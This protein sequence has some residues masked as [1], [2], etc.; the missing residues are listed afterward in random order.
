MVTPPSLEN[1]EEGG[2]PSPV[3]SPSP[4]T[5]RSWWVN[6]PTPLDNSEVCFTLCPGTPGGVELQLP[7][8][9]TFSVTHHALSHFQTL[10]P[11]LP[12]K[13]SL[14]VFA[15]QLCFPQPTFQLVNSASADLLVCTTEKV[16]RRESALA[17]PGTAQGSSLPA[18]S[19]PISP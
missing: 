13:H 5:G 9:I 1:A 16:P 8:V 6:T 7:R 2:S 12:G 15:S 17:G 19:S 18:Q 4:M 11:V 10:P 3:K 14:K